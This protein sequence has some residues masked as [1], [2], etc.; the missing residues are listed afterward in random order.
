MDAFPADVAGARGNDRAPGSLSVVLSCCRL[1]PKRK[2][3]NT[4]NSQTCAS[5]VRYIAG[6]AM[7]AAMRKRGAIYVRVSTDKHKRWP[8]RSKSCAGL[9]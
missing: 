9:F 7:E 6:S 4:G 1:K 2:E 3:S 5:H 8:T